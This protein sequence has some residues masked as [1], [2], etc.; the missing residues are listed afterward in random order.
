VDQSKNQP[1]GDDVEYA[2]VVPVAWFNKFK[3][4]AQLD[5]VKDHPDNRNSY[6]KL[7]GNNPTTQ[8]PDAEKK[9]AF[10]AV[11]TEEFEKENYPGEISNL[12]LCEEEGEKIRIPS[13]DGSD[14]ASLAL[15]DTVESDDL[16]FMN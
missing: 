10:M 1:K 3:T 11:F 4:Y 12:S 7:Y 13:T 5:L 6:D 16:K 8:T 2:F 9:E 14:L 15:K